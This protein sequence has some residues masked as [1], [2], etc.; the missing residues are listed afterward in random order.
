MLKRVG[1][2]AMILGGITGALL[3]GTAFAQDGYSSNPNYYYQRDRNWDRH[4]QREW[5]ERERKEERAEQWRQQR[6]GNREWREHEW[7]EHERHE[8]RWNG[9]NPDRYFYFGFGR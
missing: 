2:L 6:W 7:R 8:R 1:L 4:E 3:P 9:Y 5:R